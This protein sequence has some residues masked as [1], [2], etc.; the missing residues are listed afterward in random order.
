MQ[1]LAVLF[2][3]SLHPKFET[4]T[5]KSRRLLPA[6][7]HLLDVWPRERFEVLRLQLGSPGVEDL[8][9]LSTGIGL[10][11]S[12]GSHIVRLRHLRLQPKGITS[13]PLFLCVVSY[14]EANKFQV[15]SLATPGPVPH[16]TRKMQKQNLICPPS[17]CQ[18]ANL[19][20]CALQTSPPDAIDLAPSAPSDLVSAVVRDVVCQLVKQRMQHLGLAEG[21]A[22]DVCKVLG[23]AAL[24]NVG[25]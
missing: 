5:V 11:G 8:D 6:V 25:R 16:I 17:I 19:Q 4:L 1:E 13:G 9:H 22:L 3:G 21:K 14:T 12:P 18:F 7:P 23:A 15:P 20:Y 24:H 10:R 2:M